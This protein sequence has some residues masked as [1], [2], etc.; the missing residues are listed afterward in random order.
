MHTNL[1][2][3][4]SLGLD[5]ES[6]LLVSTTIGRKSVRWCFRD[7]KPSGPNTVRLVLNDARTSLIELPTLVG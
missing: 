2:S 4:V 3:R 5:S 1:G 6:A 7:R